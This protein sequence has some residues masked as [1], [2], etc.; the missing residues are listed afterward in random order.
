MNF[1]SRVWG[2]LLA[3][4]R[5]VIHLVGLIYGRV[6]AWA[7]LHLPFMEALV[8]RHLRNPATIFM[9]GAVFILIIYFAFGVAGAGLVYGKKS[10]SRF[11]ET[12][13]I[14]YPLPAAQVDNSFVWSHRFLQRLRFLNTFSQQ[15]APD[16]AKPPTNHELRVKI[17]DGLIEDKVIFL[18]AQKRQIS[19]TEPEVKAAYDKQRAQTPDFEGKI[20][21]LYGM[22][23]DEFRQVVAETLL[24]EKVKKAVLTRVHLRHI[25]TDSESTARLVKGRL[26]GGAD[27]AAMAKEFSQDAQTKDTGGDL[28]FWSQ[29]DLL[30]QISTEFETT[31][32]QLEVNKVSNPVNSKFGYHIIQVTEKS[33]DNLQTYGDWL[34]GAIGTYKIRKYIPI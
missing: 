11:T 15:A 26:E 1:L 19:V 17:L 31:A 24:K 12:L 30:S 29:G 25:L 33:G 16:A 27:F 21:Q 10:D 22:S 28:G 3:V 4:A 8:Q 14:L 9:D 34:K 2:L 23:P 6:W 5:G 18:E 7:R 13:T 32:F 20:K